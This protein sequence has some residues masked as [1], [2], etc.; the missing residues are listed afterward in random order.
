MAR[1]AALARPDALPRVVAGRTGPGVDELRLVLTV[2]DFDTAVHLYRD[3]LGMPA[4]PAVS[5][6]GGR[7]VILE[8]G[9]ATLELADPAHAAYIDG[10][11]AS[12]RPAGGV[13]IALRV[14]DVAGTT[15]L[16]RRAGIESL[17]PPTPTPF[18][19]TNARFEG[20]GGVQLTL[21]QPDAPTSGT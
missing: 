11:E 19:S 2:D 13:R 1:P 16:V 8:A 4:V 12:E 3:V 17:A 14:G 5:S 15:E 7:G 6:A 10:V 9:R 18:H 20:P 21:F